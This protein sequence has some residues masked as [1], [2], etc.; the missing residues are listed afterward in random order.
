[1]AFKDFNLKNWWENLVSTPW[2]W[3]TKGYE[4]LQLSLNGSLLNSFLSKNFAS[5]IAGSSLN[6]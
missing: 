6:V 1:M 5:A 3:M 2:H 4:K